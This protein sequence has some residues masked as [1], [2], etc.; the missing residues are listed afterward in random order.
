MTDRPDPDKTQRREVNDAFPSR[1]ITDPSL[2]SGRDVTMRRC[3]E[4]LEQEGTTLLLYGDHG[5]GKTSIWRVL[6]RDRRFEEALVVPG[7][8]LPQVFLQILSKY[9]ADLVASKL[10]LEAGSEIGGEV[11]ASF[12]GVGAKTTSRLTSKSGTE[13]QPV[14]LP[15]LNIPFLVDRL[16]DIQ[17][18][19]DFLVLEEIHSFD[20]ESVREDLVRLM[21][22]LSDRPSIKLRLVM[23][24]SARNESDLLSGAEYNR[25]QSRQVWHSVPVLPLTQAEVKDLLRSREQSLSMKFG[26]TTS[27]DLARISSGYPY[28]ANTLARFSCLL[29]LTKNY[30]EAFRSAKGGFVGWLTQVFRGKGSDESLFSSLGVRISDE[31]LRGAV[32]AFSQSAN[33]E[34]IQQYRELALQEDQD[35]TEVFRLIQSVAAAEEPIELAKVAAQLGSSE[36]RILRLIRL[37]CGGMI[38][39]DDQQ[40]LDVGSQELRWYSRSVSYL[41]PSVAYP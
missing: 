13:T 14:E 4:V 1:P 16:G 9:G 29:W 5:V 41:S 24:G 2:L 22:A 23:V 31:E 30:R 37:F 12:H 20:Q 27:D 35:T 36:E 3:R 15:R 32:A 19:V 21:K 33:A 11:G 26:G 18:S 8:S 28:I 38:E 17:Q 40:R 7:L 6:L 39:V 10:T 34:S 25:Y